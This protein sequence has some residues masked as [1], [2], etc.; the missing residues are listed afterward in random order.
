[1]LSAHDTTLVSFMSGIH[2]KNVNFPDY[3]S[4]I[5]IELR[6]QK[7]N[8]DYKYSLKW[9]Y[10]DEEININ[11][12]W[13]NQNEWNPNMVIDFLK[14]R[15]LDTSF[16]KAWDNLNYESLN[17]HF[18]LRFIAKLVFGFWTIIFYYLNYCL[19]YT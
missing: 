1:M 6:K 4:S 10:N 12:M 5:V 2:H 19:L 14:S 8:S 18:T 7:Y 3:A 9:I 15:L 11:N 17:L 16:E 13:N